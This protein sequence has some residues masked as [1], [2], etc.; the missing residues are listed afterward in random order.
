[1]R[2]KAGLI[3][4][5]N[6]GNPRDQAASSPYDPQV[7]DTQYAN[8]MASVSRKSA[9]YRSANIIGPTGFVESATRAAAQA[10]LYYDPRRS[11]PDKWWFPRSRGEANSIYREFYRKDAIIST[12]TDMY[13][14]LPWSDFDLA[15]LEDGTMKKLF[16]D[17]FT[18]LDLIPKL[19][20]FTRDFLITGE[21]IIHA[22]FNNYKG[23]WE[24]VISH[25]ADYVEVI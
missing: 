14:E 7:D 1:M 4:P 10:P 2:R 16:E 5:G 13:A 6:D 22:I 23:Y 15:N 24:R 9:I 25:N 19:P 17:M 8:K 11:T 21:L 20:D 3:I 12:A 18:D